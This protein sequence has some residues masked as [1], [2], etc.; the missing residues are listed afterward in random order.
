[1]EIIPYISVNRKRILERFDPENINYSKLW[2]IDLDA[3]R[4]KEMN[5]K[6]YSKLDF[7]D[8][9]IDISAVHPDDVFDALTMGAQRVTVSNDISNERA[10]KII[11]STEDAIFIVEDLEE[12]DNFRKL[13]AT[14]FLSDKVIP[15][16]YEE[17]YSFK[18]ECENCF[19]LVSIEEI[20]G[21]RDEKAP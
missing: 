14:K 11:D 3:K 16:V 19:K 7:L 20:N 21:R 5:F 12:A 1:M 2:I 9:F 8:L 13:G 15:P 18:I 10:R 4:G 17:F 6:L